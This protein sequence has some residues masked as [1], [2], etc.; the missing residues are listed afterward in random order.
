MRRWLQVECEAGTAY[1][2]L[3]ELPATGTYAAVAG[4]IPRGELNVLMLPQA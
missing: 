1:L 2:A 4:G 3:A